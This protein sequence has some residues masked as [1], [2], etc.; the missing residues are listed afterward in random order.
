[1]C[2]VITS[3]KTH[4]RAHL[5]KQACD[6]R[7]DKLLYM[8]SIQGNLCLLICLIWFLNHF[9]INWLEDETLPEAIPLAI[10]LHVNDY[11]ANL[12]GKTQGALKY[13]YWHYLDDKEWFYKADDY[14]YTAVFMFIYNFE[15]EIFNFRIA[16]TQRWKT[17]AISYRRLSTLQCHFTSDSNTNIPRSSQDT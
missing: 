7:C 13:L 10:S 16:G 1:M 6:R 12:W 17:C 11:S 15:F 9:C 4:S 2:W 5:I 8:S 3:P 14:T